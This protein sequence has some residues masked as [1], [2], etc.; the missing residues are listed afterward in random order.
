MRFTQEKKFIR[1]FFLPV[2]YWDVSIFPA[3]ALL[4][5]V[6]DA[7]PEEA[8][9]APDSSFFNILLPSAVNKYIRYTRRC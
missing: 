3:V 1:F 8:E 2:P 6:A 7:A 5:P 4:V 9:E